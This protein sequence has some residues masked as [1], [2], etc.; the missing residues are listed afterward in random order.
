MEAG[1]LC[2]RMDAAS[3]DAEPGAM[4]AAA[5]P[6]V[7]S[8]NRDPRVVINTRERECFA[9]QE[10]LPL[11]KRGRPDP[12]PREGLVSQWAELDWGQSHRHPPNGAVGRWRHRHGRSRD[13]GDRRGDCVRKRISIRRTW[14]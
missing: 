10:P 12:S 8:L 11:V 3:L 2:L 5:T 14:P 4:V 7:A 9:H 6:E 1:G 13:S